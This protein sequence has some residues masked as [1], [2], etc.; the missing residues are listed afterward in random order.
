MLKY[1]LITGP[2]LIAFLLGVILLDSYLDTIRLSGFWTELF[3]IKAHPDQLPKGLALFVLGLVVAPLAALELC[4]IFQANNIMTRP[5]LTAAAAMLGLILSYSIPM[6][7]EAIDAISLV[8]TGMIVVFVA[9]LLTFSRHRNVQGVVAAAGAVVFAMVYLGLMLGFLLA[10]RR[11]HSAW[12]IVGVICITKTCDSGAFFTGRAIGRHK[13][14]PWLSPGKTWEGLAGGVISAV[15]AGI[16]LALASG[17]L[18]QRPPDQPTDVV[19]IWVGAVCGVV[20]AVVGQLGDLA[21]S[22]LKRGAGIKDSSHILPGLGGVL[23]VLD[24]PL[25][26]APVAYWLLTLTSPSPI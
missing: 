1:R 9:S 22:L 5:W 26:V 14:V 16:L 23:D 15:A 2:I 24:S 8:S 17:W 6:A 10:L 3:S 21:M 7:T 25:M 4:A 13:M 18:P 20:F 11:E 12:W 19:T